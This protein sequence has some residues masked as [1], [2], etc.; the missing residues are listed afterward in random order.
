VADDHHRARELQQGVFQSTQGFHVQVV[1][2]FV[3]QQHI[4]AFDE[5]FGQVQ[6]TAFTTGERANLFLLVATVEV[7]APAIREAGHLELAHVDDVQAARDVFPHGFVVVQVIAVLV[8]KGHAHGLANLDLAAVGLLFACDQLE[9]GRFTRAVGADDAH[10]GARRHLK[11]QVVDQQT[12]AKGLA[13][14][15]ELEHL[16][17]QTLGHRN[18]NFLGLVAL[19]VVVVA[20]LFEAGQTGLALG[21]T[22][23]GVGTRPLQFFLHGLGAR[24]FGALLGGQTG[25]FLLQPAGVV[26]LVRNA[27]APVEFQNPLGG[28]VQE[29]T[30]VGDGHHGAR[31]ALQEQLE[32]V[33]RF[34][35]Q[36]VGRFI[37]QQHVGA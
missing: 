37:E 8:H 21:L 29:V 31:K 26:A 10:N 33:H 12:V 28:V 15:L 9:Q 4:A 22:A 32:P 24:V 25:V 27:G 35:V 13:D 19:L 34:G 20:Q 3:Q 14:V 17:A 5:G 36:V 2:G 23:L 30:V 6:T 7:E 18:E 1:R 11:A 16:V